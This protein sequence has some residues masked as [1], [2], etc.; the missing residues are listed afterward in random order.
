[1][2]GTVKTN[3]SVA[4]PVVYLKSEV[5]SGFA[6]ASHSHVVGDVTGLQTALDAKLSTAYTIVPVLTTGTGALTFTNLSASRLELFGSNRNRILIDATL[7][8]QIRFLFQCNV[9]GTA[10][11]IVEL[12]RSS[13][14]GGTYTLITGTTLSIG[15]TGFK[16]SGWAAIGATGEQFIRVMTQGGDGAADPQVG[17]IYIALRRV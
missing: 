8:T 6:A 10:A 1:V 4:D 3:S 14:V 2:S 7:Y 5:D 12:E 13:T 11:S 17:S 15:T 9:A 16:D